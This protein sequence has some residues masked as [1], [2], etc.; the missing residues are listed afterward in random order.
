MF[1]LLLRQTNNIIF[2]VADVENQISGESSANDSSH[3]PKKC[4]SET[5][6]EPIDLKNVEVQS[7][8][9]MSSIITTA[10]YNN[11]KVNTLKILQILE[12]TFSQDADLWEELKNLPCITQLRQEDHN[13]EAS[14]GLNE[15]IRN[16]FSLDETRI[17][18]AIETLLKT[19]AREK[20]ELEDVITKNLEIVRKINSQC[21]E[22]Y[23]DI[24]KEEDERYD[25][26]RIKQMG[27]IESEVNTLQKFAELFAGN[28]TNADFL[29]IQ[30]MLH[31]SIH[32]LDNMHNLRDRKHLKNKRKSL[33]EL[34]YQV[35]S[36]LQSKLVT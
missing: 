15:N 11:L 16:Y 3:S 19:R 31:K 23:D 33:V 1:Q 27:E 4:N 25:R 7:D 30:E 26:E 14:N 21:D 35:E 36:L 29:H 28:E 13:I 20:E 17:V 32:Q 24:F 12:I 5:V 10:E 22:N 34:I 9:K 2:T 6:T 18:A 8:L